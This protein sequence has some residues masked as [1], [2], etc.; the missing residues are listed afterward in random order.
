LD[1]T[2]LD[3]WTALVIL[4]HDHSWDLPILSKAITSDVLH[5]SA[6]GS[7][8]THEKRRILLQDNGVSSRHLEKIKGPAG[9]DLGGKTPPEIALS[10]LSEV[11]STFNSA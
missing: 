5:I 10:I 2:I 9:L 7:K 6:L 4:S 11:V 8:A 1:T 3:R